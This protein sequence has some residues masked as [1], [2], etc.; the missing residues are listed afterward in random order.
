M[1][2]QAT[3]QNSSIAPGQLLKLTLFPFADRRSLSAPSPHSGRRKPSRS[4]LCAVND[5]Q[6]VHVIEYVRAAGDFGGG[7]AYNGHYVN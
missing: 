5:R 3:D 4:G 2:D 7:R 6:Y 1:Q